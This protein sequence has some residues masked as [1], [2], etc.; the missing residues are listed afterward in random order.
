MAMCLSYM[1][2]QPC[3]VRWG[4]MVEWDSGGD[5]NRLLCLREIRER[6]NV[7]VMGRRSIIPAALSVEGN[8]CLTY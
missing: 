2:T 8:I 7:K 6:G 3:R 1:W 5:S 4:E